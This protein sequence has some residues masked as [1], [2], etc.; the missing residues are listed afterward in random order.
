MPY[1]TELDRPQRA[2]HPARTG[3]LLG[4][5]HG[6]R[7]Y[8]FDAAAQGSGG[9]PAGQSRTVHGTPSA[10]RQQRLLLVDD[11]RLLTDTLERLLE[12]ANFAVYATAQG[13]DAV[14]L[15]RTYRFDL[16]ILDLSLP[17]MSGHAVLASFRQDRPDMPVI[18]L[19]GATE[20]D[21][22][23][24]VLDAGADD[25]VTKPFQVDELIA[26]IHAVLRRARATA[27]AKMQLGRLTIDFTTHR[28]LVD[29]LVVPL[30]GKEFACLEF[31][32]SRRGST[33]TKEMFLAHLYAGRDEPEMKII[34]VFICK[35]RRKLSD[36]GAAGIIETVW[37][38][39]YTIPA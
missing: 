13:G 17:D 10:A 30:T 20:L 26:R 11:D 33:V 15:A 5:T 6:N 2:E 21:S 1:T 36:S 9:A 14:D 31:L 16:A 29:D 12:S 38:R 37:G 3:G 8:A 28:A 19:S 24:H 34:D 7:S 18:I 32:A 23:L 25:Y 35:L 22:K 4:I 39:G 27:P